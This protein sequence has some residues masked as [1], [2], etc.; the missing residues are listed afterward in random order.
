VK[1]TYVNGM[2]RYVAGSESNAAYLEQVTAEIQRREYSQWLEDRTA[3]E[4]PPS[5][6]PGRPC[7][8]VRR[9]LGID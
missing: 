5:G 9:A 2:P 1:L 6:S 8:W 7:G 3:G 4:P